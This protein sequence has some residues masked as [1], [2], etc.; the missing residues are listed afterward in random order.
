[1]IKNPHNWF[2][3]GIIMAAMALTVTW[4]KQ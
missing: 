3:V 1:L 2:V 4:C